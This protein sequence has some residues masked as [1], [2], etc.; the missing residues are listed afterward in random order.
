MFSPEFL[1]TVV[2]VSASGVLS[3]GPLFTASTYRATRL[4]ALAGL[5]CAVGHT[6]VE[7]PLV[8]GLSLGLK[9][10][11]SPVAVKLI[12]GAGGIVL[13]VLAS[14]E[15]YQ[16][17]SKSGLTPGRLPPIWDKRSGILLGIIFTGM[18]P[19]FLLWWLT[20]GWDL[21]AQALVVGLVGVLVM[22]GAHIWMDYAWLWGTATLAGR[23]KLFLGKW[24]RILL[25]V[26]GVAMGY[27]G[28]VFIKAALS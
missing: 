8:V 26:F 6:M 3:P 5:Q 22:F 18:N 11:L 28:V 19:F 27:F 15:I 7:L 1:L 17:A 20:V 23:G 21:I 14:L 25:V 2:I 9:A 10:I 4:G 12:G 13:L 24:Y 16:A